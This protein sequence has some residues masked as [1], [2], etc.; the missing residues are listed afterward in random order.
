[1]VLQI[2]LSSVYFEPARKYTLDMREHTLR[3]LREAGS[4]ILA[5]YSQEAYDTLVENQDSGS[6]E[7]V[8]TWEIERQHPFVCD[9]P[10]N[11]DIPEELIGA[12]YI[13]ADQ[14]GKM[15]YLPVQAIQAQNASEGTAVWK[16]WLCRTSDDELEGTIHALQMLEIHALKLP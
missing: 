15:Y 6:Q 13:I 4:L 8:R 3:A 1:M 2:T 14:S 9:I 12:L 11:K 5:A 10:L 7:Q 16:K